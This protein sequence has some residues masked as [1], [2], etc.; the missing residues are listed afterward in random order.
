MT[1]RHRIEHLDVELECG[2]PGAAA[3]DEDALARLVRTVLLPVVADVLDA[4][5]EPGAVLTVPQIALDLGEIEQAAVHEEAPLRLRALLSDA[6]AAAKR[7]AGGAQG[8]ARV[9]TDDDGLAQLAGF[10]AGGRLPWHADFKR[11]DLHADL[12]AQ[13]LAG[14]RAPLLRM[15]D[16]VLRR[17]AA[18]RRLVEQFPLAQVRA[19]LAVAGDATVGPWR[20]ALAAVV[21]AQAARSAAS[22]AGVSGMTAG[23]GVVGPA[24]VAAGA[25]GAAPLGP[26]D[27]TADSDQRGAASAAAAAPAL[28][29][30][31][32]FL[33]SGRIDA[34][35]VLPADAAGP[36][37]V[38]CLDAALAVPSADLAA[39]LRAALRHPDSARRLVE[40]FPS[41]QQIG[42]VRALAPGHAA[43]L[44][45]LF[46][47]LQ[48][49]RPADVGHGAGRLAAWLVVLGLALEAP[50][51]D[52][53]A[54]V[55]HAE[56]ALRMRGPDGRRVADGPAGEREPEAAADPRHERDEAERVAARRAGAAM[57]TLPPAA[58]Y[59]AAAA[60]AFVA[61]DPAEPHPAVPTHAAS[62]SAGSSRQHDA[63]PAAYA[64]RKEPRGPDEM[65]MA[66]GAAT[67]V[68]A[69]TSAATGA[70]SLRAASGTPADPDAHPLTRHTP[71]AAEPD[72][73]HGGPPPHAGPTARA[74]ASGADAHTGAA[75]ARQHPSV[76]T[77]PVA[78]GMLAPRVP[79]MPARLAPHLPSAGHT[80]VEAPADGDA[81]PGRPAPA[82]PAASGLASHPATDDANE[83]E[84]ETATPPAALLARLLT[85][86]DTRGRAALRAAL[87]RLLAAPDGARRL[88]TVIPERLHAPLVRLLVP[89]PADALLAVLGETEARIAAQRHPDTRARQ[90]RALCR[91][92]VF[93]ACASAPAGAPETLRGRL[94]AVLA[95]ATRDPRRTTP[96]AAAERLLAF[97][98]TGRLAGEAA[99][100]DAPGA[101]LDMVLA[102]PYRGAGWWAALA[103][104]LAE[105]QALRRLVTQCAGRGPAAIV[106]CAVP[107][108]ADA[109]LALADVA[110]PADAP[111]AWS[112]LVAAAVR[113]AAGL[114]EIPDPACLR[115]RIAETAGTASADGARADAALLQSILSGEVVPAEPDRLDAI[116]ARDAHA[117]AAALA[118][119]DDRAAG[120][121]RLHGLVAACG[122]SGRAALLAA[123]A[124]DEAPA[125]AHVPAVLQACARGHA[126]F[127]LADAWCD[128]LDAA[129]AAPAGRRAAHVEAR[130]PG[131]P[132][133]RLRPVPRVAPTDMPAWRAP[134]PERAAAHVL[135]R[136]LAEAGRVRGGSAP[137]T[138]APPAAPTFATRAST[139][140]HRL[141]PKS[142]PMPEPMSRQ[143]RAS[144]R[145]AV[146]VV[147]ECAAFTGL[148]AEIASGPAAGI[149][150]SGQTS[151]APALRPGAA[152]P[153]EA[154]SD[155]D[156]DSVRTPPPAGANREGQSRP[157]VTADVTPSSRAG[158]DLR[159]T[160][161]PAPD[162]SGWRA[163]I[164]SL[165][166]A[167]NPAMDGRHRTMPDA[168]DAAA[169][170]PP[171]P[172]AFFQR[173]AQTPGRGGPPGLE[174]AADPDRA[175]DVRAGGAAA[176]ARTAI[177]RMLATP[178]DTPPPAAWTAL[179]ADRPDAVRAALR[180]LAGRA[181]WRGALADALP[182][183]M[184]AGLVE[185]AAPALA[186]A[187]RDVQRHG[188]AFAA[189]FGGAW[190]RRL[191][192]GALA[193]FGKDDV[194]TARRAVLCERIVR[195]AA[196]VDPAAQAA[197]YAA[198]RSARTLP[199]GA[200]AAQHIQPPS[201]PAAAAAPTAPARPAAATPRIGPARH[202]ATRRSD[203]APMPWPGMGA[204]DDDPGIQ[205]GER[206]ALDNAGIVL[207]APYLPRLFSVLDLVRDGAFV[208]T[209]AAERAVHL[210]QYAASGETDAPEYRL[211]FNKLLCGLAPEAPVPAAVDLTQEER[212]TLESLLEALIASWSAIGR[213]SVAGLRQTFLMR[214][215]E[216]EARSD[217]WQLKVAPGPF[218]I[219][220]DRLPWSFS[221]V[222]FAWMPLPVHVTWRE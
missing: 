104:A 124:A 22:A 40:Q 95:H 109:W 38:A 176:A 111:A 196:G 10:L 48:D 187:L 63:S 21:E 47:A 93:A 46:A 213:T 44:L 201:A 97:L 117:A 180:L 62:S 152:D 84:A 101:L 197:A 139:A 15:L 55:V 173:V 191:W 99:G 206:I 12:L 188:D 33:R 178:D 9:A 65:T 175:A 198:W 210:L 169:A 60:G 53:D 208:D 151:A 103:Q 142:A 80:I 220:M 27:A 50:D 205:P 8:P 216:L 204:P 13:A 5:D 96:R 42:I 215:G 219:L 2:V 81:V 98:R 123:A 221:I 141:P 20:Q 107:D 128:V 56:Q 110:E 192:R 154:R 14:S 85:G 182:D 35:A 171:D 121:Q 87:A 64:T 32:G 19:L 39:V 73:D 51:A 218:D 68:R 75:T 67:D 86:T 195:A 59:A 168:I 186:A 83:R 88:A 190:P 148:L 125:L 6:L 138:S 166:G 160:P 72:G 94:A 157:L 156:S 74:T 120:P 82:A 7:T 36:A 58:P 45:T 61:A 184:L 137:A 185:A 28:T 153:V 214:A 24:D 37:H 129:L 16:G 149:P 131:A 159:A 222:K 181:A 143:A 79:S 189:I 164:R 52:V 163:H 112:V 207:A 105:P 212:A 161:P 172:R 66:A 134:W 135:R 77:D 100:A 43:A 18:L 71:A 4:M 69:T 126:G 41:R 209:A 179:L 130:V 122:V 49:A 118:A 31:A 3:P 92:Q 158:Y 29:A 90:L 70:T 114:D 194:A 113:A 127:P 78:D 102:S 217:D 203:A 132:V 140:L 34:G 119:Q 202:P 54:A 162:A 193:V 30:L 76:A 26:A 23:A 177:V 116:L 136:V 167:T 174:A 144:H 150:E 57:T 155:A 147:D 183:R 133:Q 1:A 211:V 89:G 199:P 108:H 145:E 170:E 106:R 165:P 11:R 25:A 146:R 200:S 17:P 115:A 91:E